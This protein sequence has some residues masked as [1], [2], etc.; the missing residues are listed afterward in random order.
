[1][2]DLEDGETTEVQGSGSSRYTLRNVGGVYSC[3]CPAWRN[4]SA[5]I[6]R[7]SCKHL[8]A[9][10]G[11]D[12]ETERVGAAGPVARPRATSAGAASADVDD[13]AVKPPPVLLAHTWENDTDLVGWWMSEKLDGVRAYWTGTEFLSRL[14]NRYHAP[15]WFTVG[16]PDH[17]LDGELWGGR[18]KFQRTVSIVRRQDQSEHWKEIEYVIFDAPAMAEPFERRLLACRELISSVTP[19]HA[20]VLEHAP[21]RDVAHLKQELARVEALGGEGLMLRKPGSKYEVGRSSTLLKVKSFFDSEARVV[22]Y[23]AGAGRHKGRT[24]ALLVEMQDGTRFSVGTGLSDRERES[25]PPKGSLITYRYQELSD[26]GVPRFPSYVGVRDDVAWPATDEVRKA[27]RKPAA[28][29]VAPTVKPPVTQPSHSS[30]PATPVAAVAAT[31]APG[32]FWRRFELVE[33]TAS[34]FWA[35]RLHGAAFTV[36]FGRIGTNGQEQTKTFADE[37]A[38]WKAADALIAEKIGKGYVEQ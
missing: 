19:P 33:G 32:A 13:G 2:P 3:S 18:K 27:T 10:R 15:A 37:R 36:S 34:K 16:L 29:G 8:R 14:G 24:G 11:S 7:R 20:R 5:G 30:K 6:E 23:V 28:G 12:A 25:P 38:A 35:I 21:C 26:G 4:Q 1:M 31:P 9:Y 17:P 22:D